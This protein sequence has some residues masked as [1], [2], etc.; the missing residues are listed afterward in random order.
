M[1]KDA[2]LCYHAV[3]K[4]IPSKTSPWNEELQTVETIPDFKYIVNSTDIIENMNQNADNIEWRKFQNYIA[5]A[6][7]NMNVRQVLN[8]KQKSLTDLS[9]I[10]MI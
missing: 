5:T 7:I 3:P 2:R 10:E 9:F 1:S 4:I 6:R 8:E